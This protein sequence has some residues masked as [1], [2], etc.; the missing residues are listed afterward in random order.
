MVRKPVS[1][2]PFSHLATRP[3][4]YQKSELLRHL[5]IER[6]EL[7]G[8]EGSMSPMCGFTLYLGSPHKNSDLRQCS[9]RQPL[10]YSYTASHRSPCI[11]VDSPRHF[12]HHHHDCHSDSHNNIILVSL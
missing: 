1:D 9:T 6:G 8:R 2:E 3:Q 10:V 5:D 4:A 7:L 12:Y 11:R